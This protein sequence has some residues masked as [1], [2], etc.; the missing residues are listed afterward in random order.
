LVSPILPACLK[1]RTLR[2]KEVGEI[3]RRNQGD[4][5]G[6]FLRI[7]ASQGEGGNRG[8]KKKRKRKLRKKKKG[9]LPLWA[10]RP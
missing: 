9:G 4:G 10:N 8:K 5:V 1:N 6:Q 3:G 2:A 7:S